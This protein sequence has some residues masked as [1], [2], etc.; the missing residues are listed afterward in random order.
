M[1]NG[2]YYPV[3]SIDQLDAADCCTCSDFIGGPCDAIS[4]ARTTFEYP[5]NLPAGIDITISI[6]KIKS[7]WSPSRQREYRCCCG[8][9]GEGHAHDL[10]SITI[11][12]SRT[13]SDGSY[14]HYTGDAHDRIVVD[15][16]DGLSDHETGR[17]C[18]TTHCLAAW[19]FHDLSGSD[20]Q[21]THLFAGQS[22]D[23]S[24]RA[25]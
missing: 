9:P 15:P 4:M 2:D 11:T 5:L 6:P 19:A 17:M 14:E 7:S 10:L 24:P 20:R 13:G 18:S 16:S 3:T 12:A 25:V 22:F 23:N 8:Y 1:G 21:A